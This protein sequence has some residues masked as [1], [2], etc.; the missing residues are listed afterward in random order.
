MF[1]KI[2][3]LFN[4]KENK[5]KS[6]SI[7]DEIQNDI[8]NNIDLSIILLKAKVLAYKLKNQEFKDWIENEL[9]GYNNND[10]LPYYRELSVA[11]QGNFWNGSWQINNQLIPITIIPKEF[12]SYFSEYKMFQGIKELESL[13]ETLKK[14]NEDALRIT[15]PSDLHSF[16][17]YRVFNNLQCIDAWRLVSGGQ[18]TQIIATTRNALLNFILELSDRYPEIE[19]DSYSAGKIPNEQI[20]QV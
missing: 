1:N 6:M 18:I 4:S 7:F 20:R 2:L 15:I 17:H 8:I 14:N 13:I 12:H 11:A 10:L 9:N 16:L 5:T 19:S 3:T